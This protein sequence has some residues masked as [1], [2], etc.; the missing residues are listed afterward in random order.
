MYKKRKKTSKQADKSQTEVFSK[1]F[2]NSLNLKSFSLI[3]CSFSLM[4]HP[5]PAQTLRFILLPRQ[6]KQAS[7]GG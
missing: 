6:S 3:A 7:A 2:Q 4:H 5:A 1:S